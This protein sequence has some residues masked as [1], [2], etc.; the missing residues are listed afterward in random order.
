MPLTDEQVDSLVAS[1]FE[2]RRE[3]RLALKRALT[4]TPQAAVTYGTQETSRALYVSPSQL[5]EL[6]QS[7]EGN[8]LQTWPMKSVERVEVNFGGHLSIMAGFDPAIRSG[9][10]RTARVTVTFRNGST[11]ELSG[12]DTVS[13]LP[14]AAVANADET[15]AF[16][17]SLTQLAARYAEVDLRWDI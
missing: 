3:G 12:A 5:A 9:E 11:L 1:P 8:R 13:L 2:N 4:E 10:I 16:V 17:E 7:V 14:G 6:T 15:V